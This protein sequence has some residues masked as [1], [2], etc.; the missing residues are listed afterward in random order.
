[1][2]KNVPQWI[3]GTF[4]LLF[5]LSG[6]VVPR[7]SEIRP[8][9]S[10]PAKWATPLIVPGVPNLWK[11]SPDLYRGGQPTKEGFKELERLGIRTN[12]NLR[13]FH[14]DRNKLHGA[15]LSHEHIYVKNW[16]AEDKEVI[17]FLQI[18]MDKSRVPVFLHCWHGSDR[19]GAFVA[20]YRIVVEGWTRQEAIEEMTQGGYGYNEAWKNLVDYVEKLDMERIKAEAGIIDG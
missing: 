20:V 1:M 7:H 14:S 11:V 12:V 2:L 16:K 10:R 15:R 19:T 3:T 13:S 8:D 9:P 6:C 5:T 17:L 18:M 4:I